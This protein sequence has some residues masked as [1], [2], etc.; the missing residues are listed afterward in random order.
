M[1]GNACQIPGCVHFELALRTT[2][3]AQ[4]DKLLERHYQND[5]SII[6]M[7]Y[8]LIRMDEQRKSAL[9]AERVTRGEFVRLLSEATEG[10]E[11]PY[12][13]C[14]VMTLETDL[15]AVDASGCELH[16]RG[17]ENG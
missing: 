10:G 14:A 8:A 15:F 13:S 2:P 17:D 3:Q 5:H 9:G 7:H 16:S 1:W 4:T 6:E 12:C 11:K